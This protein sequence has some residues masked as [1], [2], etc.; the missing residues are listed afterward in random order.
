[1]I[2]SFGTGS[3]SIWELVMAA[4]RHFVLVH[5]TWAH[6][7]WRSILWRFIP[8][9]RRPGFDWPELRRMLEE[10]GGRVHTF[11]W[12]G[13]NNH[14][15]RRRAGD[16]LCEKL[17]EIAKP[18]DRIYV[19]AHSHGGNVAL[20]ALD[21]GSLHEQVE[22]VVFLATPFLHFQLQTFDLGVIRGLR[23]VA[24]FAVFL[25]TW[26]IL[27]VSAL[28]SLPFHDAVIVFSA[29]GLSIAL[30]VLF[31]YVID[32]VMQTWRPM[33]RAMQQCRSFQPPP[34]REDMRVLVVRNVGDEATT[35][36]VSGQLL[37]LLVSL[38]WRATVFV[39]KGLPEMGIKW[40]GESKKATAIFAIVIFA[41]VFAV[42][43]LESLEE[44]PI[45]GWV[46]LAVMGV[47]VAAAAV[48]VLLGAAIAAL[49]LLRFG[50][51]RPVANALVRVSTEATP[52]G[53][54]E[55]HLFRSEG[56]AMAHSRA[57]RDKEIV[58]AIGVWVA[59]GRVPDP[60][61]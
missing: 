38:M 59:G 37:E 35:A 49:N 14:E 33:D 30:A 2:H 17:K 58:D 20:Y 36:L 32:R 22:G 19:L 27:L 15:A 24:V 13:Q 41:T 1:M 51:R 55:V 53:R 50:W 46:I 39:V 7:F 28:G 26:T 47:V 43:S 25:V 29:L 45:A 54:W 57:Y 34:P 3:G 18:G 6:G 11:V 21:D 42:Q 9:A 10:K 40:L 5:G 56:D 48:Q 31:S 23:I 60:A 61:G 8:T 16:R 12:S 44:K 4:E 52:K